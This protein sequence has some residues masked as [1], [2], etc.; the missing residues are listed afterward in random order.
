MAPEYERPLVPPL[1][2]IATFGNAQ[3]IEKCLEQGLDTNL[4][5]PAGRMALHLA[6]AAGN[7]TAI[8]ELLA[9]G[10]HVD[11]VD[12]LGETPLHH[13][14]RKGHLVTAEILLCNGAD[15]TLNNHNAYTPHNLAIQFGHTRLA[16]LLFSYTEQSRVATEALTTSR[17]K[18][19]ALAQAIRAKNLRKCRKLLLEG[20]NANGTDEH[21]MPLLQLA[22]NTMAISRIIL[23]RMAPPLATD[24]MVL[25][26]KHG[27]KPLENHALKAFPCNRL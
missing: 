26:A 21:G 19:L 9:H 22:A 15:A 25:L 12:L 8:T 14:A 23:P 5:D 13:A 6:A 3:M 17:Y 11:G 1:H 18:E 24:I 2:Q 4:R 10:A 7:N 16:Q 20:A 27:A